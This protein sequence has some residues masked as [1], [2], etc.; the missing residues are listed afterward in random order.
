MLRVDGGQRRNLQAW[1]GQQTERGVSHHL[2]GPVPLEFEVYAII[3][4]GTKKDAGKKQ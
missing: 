4:T 3:Y 1:V 2:Q